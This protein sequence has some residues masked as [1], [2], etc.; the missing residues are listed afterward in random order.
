MYK[1][2]QLCHF[3]VYR[4]KC[5]PDFWQQSYTYYKKITV[6]YIVWQLITFNNIAD[7]QLLNLS[8]IR[9][10]TMTNSTTTPPYIFATRIL[11]TMMQ[12]IARQIVWLYHWVLSNMYIT[13]PLTGLLLW[14][15]GGRLHAKRRFLVI[16]PLKYAHG[17]TYVC[18]ESPHAIYCVSRLLATYKCFREFPCEPRNASGS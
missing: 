12:H 3:H 13:S 9:Q 7:L 8:H 14:N 11:S 10:I 17:H 18:I 5:Y 16:A 6:K 15:E 4:L 1:W 2:K